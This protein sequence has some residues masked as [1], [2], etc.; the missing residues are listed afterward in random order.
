MTRTCN[1]SATSR[2]PDGMRQATRPLCLLILALSALLVGAGCASS[3]SAATPAT[4]TT[5][6]DPSPVRLPQATPAG[7]T[8]LYGHIT[9]LAR[10]GRRFEM[11][12]DPAL[13]LT[14][15]TAGRA[16]VEDKAIAPGEPVSND[17]YIRDESHRLLTYVVSADAHVS[18]LTFGGDPANLGATPITVSELAQLLNGESPRHLRLMEPKAGFWIRIGNKYPS[19]VLSL[20]QQYQP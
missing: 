5:S 4:V 6:R 8:T 2:R 15:V 1:T 9:S 17:Y 12:F 11:G 13:W 7:E 14:G 19:P 20:N 3:R 18:V 16:A 10:T